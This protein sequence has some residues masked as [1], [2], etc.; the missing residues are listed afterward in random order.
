MRRGIDPATSSVPRSTNTGNTELN[1]QSISSRRRGSNRVSIPPHEPGEPQASSGGPKSPA[2]LQGKNPYGQIL[3]GVQNP[4]QEPKAAPAGPASQLG[5]SIEGRPRTSGS[6]KFKTRPMQPEPERKGPAPTPP[7]PPAAPLRQP[8]KTV[9]VQAAKRFFESKASEGGTAPPLPPPAVEKIAKTATGVP[10]IKIDPL[11]S[12]LDPKG[13]SEE[14]SRPPRAPSPAHDLA[15]PRKGSEPGLP[16]PRPPAEAVKRTDVSQRTN[17]FT[18]QKPEPAGSK[19]VVQTATDAQQADL[20]KI[21]SR[22]KSKSRSAEIVDQQSPSTS[23]TS[24]IEKNTS[25]RKR[26]TNVVQQPS[27]STRPFGY[28]NRDVGERR[29]NEVSDATQTAIKQSRRESKTDPSETGEVIETHVR[30]FGEPLNASQHII[31]LSHDGSSS[32]RTLSRRTTAPAVVLTGDVGVEEGY[33][34]IDVPDH[35]DWRGSYGRRH[36]KDFGYPGARIRPRRTIAGLKPLQD[37]GQWVKRTC[38]HFS[39]TETEEPREELPKTA[40]REC[41]AQASHPSC[42]YRVKPK[43]EGARKRAATDSSTS[44]SSSSKK[45][46]G[47]CCAPP[48]RRKHHSEC[49]SPDR[50]GDTFAKDLGQII[51]AI[52]EEHAN[53]LE[54]VISNIRSSQPSLSQLRRVSQDLVIRSQ[55]AGAHSSPCYPCGPSQSYD[56]QHVCQ[57]VCEPVCRPIARPCRPS[58]PLVCEYALPCPYVPPKPAEKLNVGKTGQLDPNLN[59]SKSRLRETTKTVPDL[60]NLV[61]SAADDLGV[62]L[63]KRPTLHDEE[64]FLNAPVE[65]IQRHSTTRSQSLPRHSSLTG[66]NLPPVEENGAE[67]EQQPSEDSWLQKTRRQL[68][69]LSEVRSQMMDE[70]DTIAEDLGVRLNEQRF[71]EQDLDPLQRALTRVSTGFSRA[72][73]RLRNK[74]VDT[75]AD[76]LPRMLDQEINERRL[77][78]V[79]TRIQAQSRRVSSIRQG[80]QDLDSIPPEEVQ[81][82]LEVAQAELPAAID[83]ICTV[84]ETLPAVVPEELEYEPEYEEYPEPQRTYTEPILELQ[85]RVADLERRFAGEEEQEREQEPISPSM[86]SEQLSPI[87]FDAPVER[88][89]EESPE[90]AEPEI[91][92]LPVKRIASRKIS[93]APSRRASTMRTQTGL[94]ERQVERTMTEPIGFEVPV[95]RMADESPEEEKYELEQLETEQL[96]VQ[97]IPSRQPS[98]PRSQRTSRLRTRTGLSHAAIDPVDFKAPVGRMAEES[99]DESLSEPEMPPVERKASRQSSYAPSRRA[100]RIRTTAPSRSAT[101]PVDFEPP[102]ERMADVSPEREPSELEKPPVERIATKKYSLAPSRRVTTMRIVTGFDNGEFEAPIMRMADEEPEPGPELQR[103]ASRQPLY[104][105]SRHATTSKEPSP[106]FER[107][108]TFDFEE[109]VMLMADEEPPAEEEIPSVERIASRQ[110]SYAPSRRATT[111]REPTLELKRAPTEQTDFDPPVMRMAEEE[112]ELEQELPVERIASRQPTLYRRPAAIY[113]PS[114]E[115]E[116]VP[117]ALIDF[118]APLMRMSDDDPQAEN[119]WPPFVTRKPSY[120]PSRRATVVR[121][122]SPELERAYTEQ[123][124]FDPPVMR[125]ADEEPEIEPDLPPVER[126]MARQSTAPRRVTAQFGP[127]VERMAEGEPEIE[128]EIVDEELEPEPEP[129]PEEDIP[130]VG[131]M[132]TR[133]QRMPRRVTTTRFDPLLVRMVNEEREPE[134][135][136]EEDILPAERMATRQPSMPRRATTNFEPPVMRIA[137]EESEPELEQDPEPEP[138][139]ET[140]EDILPVERIAT[141]QPT[142][143]HRATTTRFDPPV[144]RMAE[145]DPDLEPELEQPPLERRATTI[146]TSTGLTGLTTS[147]SEPPEY[148]SMDQMLERAASRKGTFEPVT[149]VVTTPSRRETEREEPIAIQDFVPISVEVEPT[150]FQARLDPAFELRRSSTTLSMWSTEAVKNEPILTIAPE[151]EVL[152]E[153][154]PNLERVASIVSRKPTVVSQKSTGISRQPTRQ[155]TIP[156]RRW[157]DRE[158]SPSP[159]FEPH[160]VRKATTMRDKTPTPELEQE[161]IVPQPSRQPSILS[162]K[163]TAVS[164]KPNNFSRQPTRQ[165]TISSRR[166]TIKE[167][168]PSPPLSFSRKTTTVREQAP[169]PDLEPHVVRKATSISRQPTIEPEREPSHE[170]IL[171]KAT[172]VRQRTPSPKPLSRKPTTFRYEKTPSPEFEPPVVRKATGMSRK[173]TTVSRKSTARE[174]SPS[175]VFEPPVVRKATGL[176][177]QPTAAPPSQP[178]SRKSTGISRRSSARDPS[179]EVDFEPP[180]VRRATGISREPTRVSRQPTAREPSPEPELKPPVVRKATVIH[181]EPSRM[182]RQPTAREPSPEPEFE[183]PVVRKATGILKRSTGVTRQPT[184]R[185]PSLEPDLEPPVVRKATGFSRHST[186]QEPS[187]KPEFEPPVARK[188]TGISRKSTDVSRQPTARGQSPEPEFEAP[189]VRKATGF[190]RQ[191][192]AREPSPEIELPISRKSTGISRKPT[193]RERTPS[194]TPISRE[195]SWAQPQD[196]GTSPDRFVE[197][198][199]PVS[200]KATRQ[201]ARIST[202]PTS[203]D[204]APPSPPSI[205][206]QPTATSRRPTMRE[207][208]PSGEVLPVTRLAEQEP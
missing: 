163:L 116:R 104:A 200:R 127:P 174:R 26:S 167:R 192:T 110:L 138:V 140:V 121:E 58:S 4:Y 44:S 158:E 60:I 12:V 185:E 55:F 107:V 133:Q 42:P 207:Q 11:Q 71:S 13:K 84:L 184:A 161:E 203:Q 181:L 10:K 47:A 130:L 111:F 82:W 119:V 30:N 92:Q 91:E 101:G 62:D 190:S 151:P 38:G 76:E 63:D 86:Y 208:S 83:S 45:G 16:I 36:T 97:R 80:L 197:E 175:P 137:D 173:P 69:E 43:H 109:P 85:D 129:E 70:L 25:A 46:Y 52:L 198:L 115:L 61:N 100:S 194:P 118:D 195:D 8:P 14:E 81:G 88:M 35:V 90:A 96:S 106:E 21:R 206:R 64:Q 139:P 94:S 168:T 145:E 37:P 2:Y 166:S 53:T 19:V 191:S 15:A 68:T 153:P 28:A 188:A 177:R 6:F 31:S 155:P 146:R 22:R 103:V 95:E 117:A 143:P 24:A 165:P 182:S 122:P 186:A 193:M 77:S 79:L 126:V 136:P 131:R 108:P 32:D 128:P 170:P 169:S 201:F 176:S 120:A 73:T 202:Q 7:Q 205:S 98:Y 187:P 180:V 125:M 40:C 49:I 141:R 204:S 148:K 105:P 87:D 59:D 179:P 172:T 149:R 66:P 159:E 135:E 65:R 1:Q 160:V 74:S 72:S 20:A 48:Q 183:L 162:R 33:H 41:S 171:R 134:P 23:S 132:A 114:P 75:V 150:D 29:L 39:R 123:I 89:S 67:E 196:A 102:V 199:L 156:S 152:E 164:R 9:S 154:I 27:W 18:R 50:C 17:P 5:S 3:E 178:V 144:M 93:F 112:P 51:D 147:S 189:V 54:H 157:T 34:H 124:D 56:Y 99:P 57:P 142:L 78:R 113:E